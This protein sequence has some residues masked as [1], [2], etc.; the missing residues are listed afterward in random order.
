MIDNRRKGCF[1]GAIVGD[2]LGMPYE[3]KHSNEIK[4]TGSMEPGGPF[5]LPKGCWTDDTVMT[6]CLLESIYLNGF[7]PQ[8][9]L[10]KYLRWYEDGY[11]SPTKSCFDIGNQTEKAIN[12][13]SRNLL[14]T[15]ATYSETSAGNGSLMRINAIPL[16][17]SKEED[18][19][20]YAKLATITTHNNPL[21]I[22]YSVKFALLLRDVLNGMLINPILDKYPTSGVNVV[23]GFVV[24][25]YELAL[26]AFANTRSFSEC[27]EYVIKKGGDTDTNACIAGMLAGAYYG[28]DK[29]PQEWVQDLVQL[30][31]LENFY[32]LFSTKVM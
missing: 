4:Y 21:C 10:L 3:F 31:K 6:L 5:N 14:K 20:K 7:N 32:T 27:M 28:Y 16:M 2:A 18:V 19:K 30:D 13:F 29:I 15:E 26:N 25:S 9:Q 23:N 1:F 11:M 22:E 8:N 12:E 17:Y 24:G